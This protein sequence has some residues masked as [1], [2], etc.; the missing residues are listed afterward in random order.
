MRFTP[1]LRMLVL[2]LASL[3]AGGCYYLQAARGQ[4]EVLNKREPIDALIEDP[5]TPDEL[6]ARLELLRAARDF[7]VTELALPDNKSYRTYSDLDRDYAVWNVVAAPEL[8]VKPRTWCFPVAG[9]VAYRGYFAEEKAWKKAEELKQDGY[10]TFVGGATAYSTLGNFNDPV[11]STMLGRDDTMLVALLFHELAHQVL[12]VKGDTSFNESFATAIEELGIER[13][14][15][16]EG[17]E[18]EFERW[19]RYKAW[20]EDLTR[21]ALEARDDLEALFASDLDDAAKRAAKAA[22]LDALT[23]A[24]LARASEAGVDARGWWQDQPLNNARLASWSAYESYVPAFRQLFIDCDEDFDCLYRRA[25]ELAE[26]P[27]ER[28]EARID[29]LVAAAAERDMASVR[30]AE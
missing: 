5:D 25:G 12:Y 26:L 1:I 14:L 15:E 2:L 16:R 18:A 10:D 6:A 3:L 21:I 9:C 27:G 24:L 29:A 8:S 11:L 30:G 19:Q 13:W 17:T 4:L 22:R 28:R 23:D 7:S 20:S